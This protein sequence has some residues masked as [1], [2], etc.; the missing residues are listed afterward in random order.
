MPGSVSVKNTTA[1]LPNTRLPTI[2][3]FWLAAWLVIG[4]CVCRTASSGVAAPDAPG[5]GTLHPVMN[6]GN[7]NIIR[8]VGRGISFIIAPGELR[9]A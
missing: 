6:R 1:L 5:T 3:K 7:A 8:R 2:V 4:L 9:C